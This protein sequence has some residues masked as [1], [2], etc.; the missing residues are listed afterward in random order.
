MT[1][2]SLIKKFDMSVTEDG[3]GVS[4][5]GKATAAEVT[6]IRA[7]K[8]TFIADLNKIDAERKARNAQ[9]EADRLADLPRKLRAEYT[10]QLKTGYLRV[11]N[12]QVYT[13]AMINGEFEGYQLANDDVELILEIAQELGLVTEG[14]APKLTTAT[15]KHDNDA[16]TAADVAAYNKAIAAINKQEAQTKPGYCPVCSTYEGHPGYCYGDCTAN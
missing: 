2:A 8:M 14:V 15:A 1:V 11:V 16:V 4:V 5:I 3:N 10:H 6:F 12:G 7:N 13:S 9:Y